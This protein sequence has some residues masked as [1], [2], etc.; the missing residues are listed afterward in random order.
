MEDKS[1]YEKVLIL[2]YKLSEEGITV[3]CQDRSLKT[4]KNNNNSSCVTQLYKLRY[5]GE[6][7]YK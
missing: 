1:N 3:L 4:A 7:N 2:L 6:L 5:K